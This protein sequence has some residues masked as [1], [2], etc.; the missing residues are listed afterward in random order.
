MDYNWL[1]REGSSDPVATLQVE[2]RDEAQHSQVQFRT[3]APRWDE[4][5]T[6]PCEDPS[7][8]LVVTIMD[9]DRLGANDF[10]GRVRIPVADLADRELHRHTRAPAPDEAPVAWAEGLGA[11]F[12]QAHAGVDRGGAAR[13]RA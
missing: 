13:G 9:Y 10:M 7:E 6:L 5:F 4:E 8:Q 1:T 2:G 11:A 12:P 3:V